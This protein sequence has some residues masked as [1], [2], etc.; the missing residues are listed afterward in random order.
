M[1]YFY[2]KFLSY[3]SLLSLWER[4]PEGRERVRNLPQFEPSP[5]ASRRP[6]PEG[7]ESA[8][9]KLCYHLFRQF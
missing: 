5:G 9:D 2:L 8:I 1:V 6:L 7:E 4:S 3:P